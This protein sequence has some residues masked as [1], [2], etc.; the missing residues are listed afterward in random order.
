[1]LRRTFIAFYLVLAAL[2]AWAQTPIFDYPYLMTDSTGYFVNGNSYSN[3]T[4]G[5]WDG[6]GSLDLMVGVFYNGN[7]YYYHN[8][9]AVGQPPVFQTHSLLQADGAILSVTYD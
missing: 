8:S 4:F 6:D 2:T 7:I 9:A 1:M 5:D 3:P